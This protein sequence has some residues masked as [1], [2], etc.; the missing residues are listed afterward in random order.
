MRSKRVALSRRELLL[1][2]LAYRISTTL[3]ELGLATI[4]GL[5]VGLSVLAWI[6]FVNLLK[7][8]WYSLFDLGWFNFMRR[9]GILPR[10]KRW[11]KIEAA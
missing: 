9:P 8:V 1:K 4:V 6:L 5:F 7:L 3:I 11:L 2:S 10:L